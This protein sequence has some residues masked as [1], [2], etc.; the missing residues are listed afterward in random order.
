MMN[1][2]EYDGYKILIAVTKKYCLFLFSFPLLSSFPLLPLFPFIFLL[3]FLV[4]VRPNFI[5]HQWIIACD[6]ETQCSLGYKRS[7]RYSFCNLVR[8][9]NKVV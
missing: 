6:F 7:I 4:L 8:D 5:T 1:A 9:H 3:S 2:Y